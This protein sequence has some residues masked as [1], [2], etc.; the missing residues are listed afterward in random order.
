M[1]LPKNLVYDISPPLFASQIACRVNDNTLFCCNPRALLILLMD[2]FGDPGK[3]RSF[4]IRHAP[5]LLLDGHIK[6]LILS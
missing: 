6:V 1:C 4:T 2:M 5:K 3:G